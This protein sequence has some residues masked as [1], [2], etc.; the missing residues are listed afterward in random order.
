M[1]E[2]TPKVW[3]SGETDLLF[4]LHLEKDELFRKS[5]I[6][7]QIWNSIAADMEK[8]GNTVCGGQSSNKWKSLKRKM[9]QLFG[10]KPS[11]HPTFTLHLSGHSSSSDSSSTD[12]PVCKD[13]DETDT[14]LESD[15]SDSESV[16]HAVSKELRK[17]L[18]GKSRWETLFW[19][20]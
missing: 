1:E 5:K 7:A 3:T 13:K 14:N 10:N 17:L 18:A 15:S 2:K 20:F 9:N 8:Q 16:A 11:T 12:L 19:N 4:A 6:H